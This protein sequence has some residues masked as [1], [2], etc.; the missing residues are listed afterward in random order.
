MDTCSSTAKIENRTSPNSSPNCVPQGLQIRPWA[1]LYSI[2]NKGTPTLT[3]R[4]L[5]EGL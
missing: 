5:T 1:P 2:E 3:R 4:L